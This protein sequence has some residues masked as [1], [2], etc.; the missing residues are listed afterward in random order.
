MTL[1]GIIHVYLGICTIEGMEL[2]GALICVRLTAE[3]AKLACLQDLRAL[4]EQDPETPEEDAAVLEIN[5][6][7]SF[8][9]LGIVTA[10][11]PDHPGWKPMT[12]AIVK[13]PVAGPL[14]GLEEAV[15]A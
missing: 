7:E 1:E 12:Y 3:A 6:G 2:L 13:V 11:V 15:A 5:W 4:A 10:G 14:D 8:P 9:A